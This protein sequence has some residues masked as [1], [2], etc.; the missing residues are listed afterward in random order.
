MSRDRIF[1]TDFVDSL[2][3][4]G[5]YF[6]LKTQAKEA[7]K[8]TDEA[9]KGSVAR[10]I[11]KKRLVLLKKGFYLINPLEYK[12][13]GAPPPEW[14]IDQLMKEYSARYYVGL[15][16]AA[17]LHGA[18]H[19]QP[20]IYQVITNK[21]LQSIKIGKAYIYFYFKKEVEE[22][23]ILKVK[24]PTGHMNVSSP[25]LTAFDLMRYVKQSGFLNHIST[26][27]TQLGEQINS[28]KLSKIAPLFPQP[29]I[30]KTGYILDYV[31]FDHKTRRL[32]RFV[33]K[34]SPRYYPL[35]PDKK[36]DIK[37]K[38]PK[39]HLYINEDLELGL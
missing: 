37:N 9:L 39:W 11:K 12:N 16:T 34:L 38:N 28:N 13:V 27:F 15:L 1:L 8:V 7:L 22:V 14:F 23:G 29:C 18:S 21:V 10:L 26:I 4:S 5:Q 3:A 6:L 36:W 17:S 35:S 20:Q 25:E 33:Q 32:L 24:T 31:G 2:Q 30:Q 19:Q